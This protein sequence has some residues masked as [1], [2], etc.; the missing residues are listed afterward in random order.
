M[1]FKLTQPLTVSS[2]R[3][4]TVRYTAKEKGE[5]LVEN[6]TP[7]PYGLRN[8]YRNLK[9]E[10]LSIL[11]PETARSWIRLLPPTEYRYMTNGHNQRPFPFP[12]PSCIYRYHCIMEEEKMN[13]LILI[14]LFLFLYSYSY[15]KQICQRQDLYRIRIR[16]HRI[17][18]FGPLGS[19]STSQR[20]GSGSFYHYAKIVKKTLIP[21]ILWLFMTFYLWKM[22]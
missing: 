5:N 21:T 13:I 14:Y 9:S 10:E 3:Y 8:P 17:P 20:C 16:I 1:V 12:N 6:H 11:C 19:G 18:F 7:L 4:C 2:V 15:S 22:M